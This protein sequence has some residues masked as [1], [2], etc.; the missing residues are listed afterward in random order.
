VSSE[1]KKNMKFSFTEK[2]NN[3]PIL[4][5]EQQA[6]F[7]ELEAKY[8][9]KIDKNDFLEIWYEQNPDKTSEE[10]DPRGELQSP[11]RRLFLKKSV[12]GAKIVA[13]GVAMAAMQEPIAKV[14]KYFYDRLE[15]EI[16]R[17]YGHNKNEK[18]ERVY[19]NLGD[20]YLE[21]FEKLS[22]QEKYFPSKIFTPD[23]LIA[24]QCQESGGEASA[25]SHKGASGVMQN[26][27]ISVVDVTQWLNMSEIKKVTNWT[28]RKKL[29]D[30]DLDELD[31]LRTETDENS[32]VSASDYGRA[33]GKLHLMQLWSR[34]KAGRSW[35]PNGDTTNA[36]P[37]QIKRAQEEILGSYNAGHKRIMGKPKE[38]WTLSEPKKYVERINNY[39][40]R[41]EGIRNTIKEME[42]V[43][44]GNENYAVREIALAMN[45]VTGLEGDDREKALNDVKRSYLSYFKTINVT[46]G[47]GPTYKEIDKSIAGNFKFVS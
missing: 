7:D 42:I 46:N 24:L 4:T 29:S 5:A 43:F 38:E 18:K 27:D 1:D 44:D 31:S 8:Q 26:M 10:K 40:E 47:R 34:Y 37:E 35:L 2:F 20:Y 11:A 30:Q 16:K 28:V 23:F 6:K 36:T 15:E 12:K 17:R 32:K 41:I 39:M 13:G 19:E 21:A 22:V 33:L 14:G 3:E 9:I 25:R 45:K